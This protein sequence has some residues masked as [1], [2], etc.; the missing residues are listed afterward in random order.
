[1]DTEP[2]VPWA[3]KSKDS[4]HA[5]YLTQKYE[6]IPNPGLSPLLY[7]ARTVRKAASVHVRV[8]RGAQWNVQHFQMA[9]PRVQE[10]QDCLLCS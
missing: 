6:S 1:M 10:N 3:L 4:T 5:L 9:V 2:G 7:D 8:V